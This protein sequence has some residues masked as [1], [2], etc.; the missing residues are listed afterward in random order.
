M[1]GYCVGQSANWATNFIENILSSVMFKGQQL[2]RIGY[3]LHSI[4]TKNY[5]SVLIQ[6]SG[7]ANKYK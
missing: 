6:V 3:I 5:S 1:K 4:L 7:F 2:N